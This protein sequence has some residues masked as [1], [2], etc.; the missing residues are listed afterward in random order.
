MARLTSDIA[1]DYANQIIALATQLRNIRALIAE[2]VTLNV[3]SP[4][5]NLWATFATTN[6]NADG[7]LATADS[8]PNVAHPIDPRVYTGLT[9]A[10][11]S[12]DLTNA[13]QLIVDFQAFM[14][15]TALVANGARPANINAVTE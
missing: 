3:T 7:T 15:G 11:K 8:T 12:G 6:T 2:I 5:G 4:F 13:L 1:I 10:V 9:R 14:A